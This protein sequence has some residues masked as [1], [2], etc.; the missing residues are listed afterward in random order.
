MDKDK[1]LAASPNINRIRILL[2]RK[3]IARINS[4]TTQMMVKM[5]WILK[6]MMNLTVRVIL[7][8]KTVI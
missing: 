4:A 2:N 6:T 7:M 5:T 3:T 1:I 8:V